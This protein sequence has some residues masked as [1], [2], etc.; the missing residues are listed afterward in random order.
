MVSVAL[1][2][3]N[4]KLSFLL[5][6]INLGVAYEG[7]PLDR[8]LVPCV[9][10]SIGHYSVEL[11]PSEV[12]EKS[13]DG[14][15]PVPSNIRMKSDS[16]DSISLMWDHVENASFYQIEVYGTNF[17]SATMTNVFTKTGLCETTE[18]IFRVRAVRW[19]SVSE[20]SYG[21]KKSTQKK[22]FENC[23]W[24]GCPGYVCEERK[25]ALKEMN[26]RAA[27]KTG[28][29]F[30]QRCTIIGNTFIPPDR[31]TMFGVKVLK[32]FTNDANNIYVG[33][34]PFDI[35][36]GANDNAIKCGWYFICY[37]S[38]LISGPP[39][40]YDGKEYIPKEI[41]GLRI[42]KGNTVGVTIDTTVGSISFLVKG[43]DYGIAY[44]GIPLDKPLVPCVILGYEG[45][46][47]EI[48]TDKERLLYG[49]DN[50]NGGECNIS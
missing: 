41:G 6:G 5:D 20:W 21:L 30:G 42:R 40:N 43:V 47:V 50:S 44:K 29:V 3:T 19:N 25:Y 36:Q 32:S 48:I 9:T 45:D 8:P 11:D 17:Q 16:W 35:D 46:C 24:R 38:T 26:I 33:V 23:V 14:S 15:V 1:D 34:A 10:N 22:I 4:A 39:Q 2:T 31:V 7:I 28:K 37:N 27:M 13:A 49:S 12:K 18:Y